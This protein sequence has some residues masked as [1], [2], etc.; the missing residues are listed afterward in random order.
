MISTVVDSIFKSRVGVQCT[1]WCMLAKV[2]CVMWMSW[3]SFQCC[4]GRIRWKRCTCNQGSLDARVN[5]CHNPHRDALADNLSTVNHLLCMY[6]VGIPQLPPPHPLS[7][8]RL[9]TKRLGKSEKKIM[10]N[11]TLGGLAGWFWL[12][13]ACVTGDQSCPHCPTSVFHSLFLFSY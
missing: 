8:F 7:S 6:R 13:R 4:L 12:V 10:L 1:S 5:G 2:L 3:L 11:R 9:K